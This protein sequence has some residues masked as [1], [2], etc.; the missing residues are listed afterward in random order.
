MSELIMS[1]NL[2][3]V[4][5]PKTDLV[6][7]YNTL[8]GNP[9]VLNP[10][11][12][13]FLN[14]FKKGL[15]VNEIKKL[16][17]GDASSFIKEFSEIYFLVSPEFNER[18]FI[19]ERKHIYLL[20]VKNKKTIE[21]ISLSIS[22]IC[23]FGC[24]H[25]MFFQRDNKIFVDQGKIM[26]WE[27][28]K[29]CVDIYLGLMKDIGITKGRIHFGNAEPLINWQVIKQTLEYCRSF[30]K[31]EFEYAINTNLYLLE[32]EMAKI[33]RDF[34]VQI[35]ASLDGLEKANDLIRITKSG[36]GTFRTIVDKMNLLEKINY[37]LDG[38]SITVTEKNFP[39]IDTD[40]I[41]FTWQ[42]G[43]K[44]IAFDYDLINITDVSCEEKVRK[45]IRLKSYADKLNIY[46]DGTW[47][48][49]FRRLISKSL[50]RDF[51]SFCSAVEGRGL[52]FNPDG[53]IKACDYSKSK[54]GE[55]NRLNEIFGK[56]SQLLKLVERRFPGNN[57]LC[58][59]CMIENFC[60]GQCHITQAANKNISAFC[61]FYKEIT[62][63]LLRES[64]EDLAS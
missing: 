49:P 41:D 37:P 26:N 3:I 48:T 53:S 61:D 2:F 16:V 23:N 34:K 25:C 54:I 47:G 27:T 4:I 55:I 7:V 14:L 52:T 15:N 5:S 20:E 32:E 50:I 58:K 12:L 64:I 44:S 38:I 31:Y 22:N 35:A 42:R 29:R 43:M 63:A 62:L 28:A 51:Y 46:F 56:N 19:E 36:Q 13:R 9:K 24:R 6:M 39:F 57:N 1:P 40:I 30:S 8:F 18:K 59:N 33:L 21:H 60:G 17:D 45:I 11:G 10:E